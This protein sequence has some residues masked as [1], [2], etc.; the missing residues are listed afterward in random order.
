MAIASVLDLMVGKG[1]INLPGALALAL[2]IAG[3]T[4]LVCYNL[5]L[6]AKFW[7]DTKAE[8]LVRATEQRWVELVS[9]RGTIAP[10]RVAFV[11]FG[12]LD[13]K[14]DTV[15]DIVRWLNLVID[16]FEFVVYVPKFVG[17]DQHSKVTRRSLANVDYRQL[18]QLQEES[19]RLAAK[20]S[21]DNDANHCL[22]TRTV[23][24]FRESIV[25]VS[26]QDKQVDQAHWQACLART[27]YQLR[28][29]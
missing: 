2:G 25:L 24:H 23:S 29:T 22:A 28:G 1:W 8:R 7:L 27:W 16:D 15:L 21:E 20:E 10:I 6:F 3:S 18:S 12:D 4:W 17:P 26:G 11:L 14:S 19:A 5:H 13:A 9:G